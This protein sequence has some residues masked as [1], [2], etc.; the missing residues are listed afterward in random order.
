L[1]DIVLTIPAVELYLQR[2]PAHKITYVVEEKFKGIGELIPGIHE[3][4]VIP[5]DMPLKE[6]LRFRKEMRAKKFEVAVDFHSGPKSALL[7][8]LSGAKKRIGYRTPNRNWAYNHLTPR[9]Q[10]GEFSH[11]VFNQVKL[12]EHVGIGTDPLPPY[13]EIKIEADNVNPELKLWLHNSKL[14]QP[15]VAVHVGAGNRFR[16]WGLDRFE[17]LI[18]RLSK[19]GVEVALVG[20]TPEE[21]EKG[22]VLCKRYGS[23]DW[24]G[25]LNIRETLYLI[26]ESDVYFGV[27]SGPLHL[28]S[29]TKTPIVAV[30][31]PNI[32]EVSG[33]WRREKVELIQLDMKCRPCSQRSCIYDTIRC[34]RDIKAETVYEAI[35]RYIQ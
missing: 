7:T 25:K 14:N 28:A 4:K 35:I 27:D 19:I 33:P 18:E 15:V 2:H 17:E 13:P 6:I 22:A 20:H 1:G 8:F 9:N 29:L 3:L 11:S 34:M 31:G 16:D 32:P 30:Y 12:L 26:Q 24:T 10:E 21:R 23:M 5:R